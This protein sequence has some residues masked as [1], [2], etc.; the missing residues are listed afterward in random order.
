MNKRPLQ[1]Q[2]YGISGKRYKELCGFCEQ[3]PEWKSELALMTHLKA[4]QTTGMPSSGNIGDPTANLAMRRAGLESKVDVIERTAK[5]AA[6]QL[7]EYI[8]QS[9]CY[10]KPYHY[11][12]AKMGM[13]SSDKPFYTQRRY[14]FYLLDRRRD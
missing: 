9:V 7:W 4:V 5:E 8:I 2:K 3:Y 11:L 14:F 1:L 10:G 6:P 12:V 13:P